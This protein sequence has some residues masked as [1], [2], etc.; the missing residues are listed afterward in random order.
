MK[1]VLAFA[2][3]AICL[4][5]CMAQYQVGDRYASFGQ[6]DGQSQPRRR[7]RNQAE[8]LG[9]VAWGRDIDAAKAKSAETGKPI[10]LLFQ[11][12]PG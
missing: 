3:V 12:V 11:E 8:E 6:T 2:L 4:A 10:L 7:P 1:L 5:S 9:Q